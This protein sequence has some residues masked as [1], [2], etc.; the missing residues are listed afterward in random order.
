MPKESAFQSVARRIADIFF[1]G[2]SVA[3]VGQLVESGD[4]WSEED[5][6][7]LR[8]IAEK[9]ATA[10]RAPEGEQKGGGKC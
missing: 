3:L 6:A 1:E 7:A 5:L 4:D 9:K 2:S 10:T 8:R